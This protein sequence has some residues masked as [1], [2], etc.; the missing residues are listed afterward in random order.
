[1]TDTVHLFATAGDGPEECQ[2]ALDGVL[3]RF[4]QEAARNKVQIEIDRTTSPAG[5]LSAILSLSGS[6]AS[7]LARSWTG[8]VLWQCQSPLRPR[9]R[10]KNWF[11]GFF[12][13]EPTGEQSVEIDPRELTYETF[14]A[15]G[16]GGQ[17]QNKT[18]S[19]VRV[20]WRGYSATS[21]S[22]RSQ[23]RNKA[24]ALERL[25]LLLTQEEAARRSNSD[26]VAHLLHRKIERGSP[27]LT[28]EGLKFR[29][30]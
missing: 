15:G 20:R 4:E 8:T 30:I 2:I 7:E 25:K 29:R 14:R 18:D 6:G 26:K 21:R 24:L 11:V 13:V 12:P 27:V 16:P 9:H 1:M 17:H 19:A 10:R 5:T 23:H 28:F 3:D 22:E